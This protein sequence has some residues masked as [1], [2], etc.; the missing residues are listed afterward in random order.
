LVACLVFGAFLR[1]RGLGLQI[2]MDDEWH[3]L[4]FALSRDFW[5]L[6]THFSRAGA[7]SVPFNLYLRA[8]LKS[9]GWTEI[10]IALPSL[11]AGIGLLWVFPRWVWRRFGAVAGAVTAALLAIAP[12]LVFYSRVARAYSAVLLLECLALIAL[13]EWLHTARR[14]HVVGLVVFGAL[15]IWVHASALP[16]LV[17]AVAAAAGHR[18]LRA[19]RAPAP[20]VPLAWHVLLAGLGMLGL[21]G[22]LWFPAL[23][24]PMPEI[25]HASGQVSTHTFLDACQIFIGTAF[26][27]LQIV[28]L[29]VALM[30]LV[31]ASRIARQELLI[32]GAAAGGSLFALL[33]A[34]PNASGVAGVFVRYLLP[35]Y[36]LAGLTV[37]V[38]MA[39]LMAV[40]L[41]Q[42]QILVL[43]ALAILPLGGLQLRN[44]GLDLLPKGGA[45]VLKEEHAGWLE[46]DLE[47]AL[48]RAK[49]EHKLVLVD[50]YADWCAQC[51]ELDEK[52][53]P[54]TSVKQWIAQ[55]AVPIRID[56]DARRKD[57]AT[58][59][60]I[61]SYPTV[62]LLDTE[63]RELRRILGFQK[64]ET[65]RTWLAGK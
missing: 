48:A 34:R 57:L 41:G 53:W 16:A 12:F 29:V 31:I 11:L 65:M 52:T 55:N 19:P 30:G 24:T 8:L 4:D 49:V 14:R 51:K 35:T 46:Q 32:L 39:V 60:Q 59:L 63:G 61:R 44:S 1:L 25:W 28:Y 64:P 38:V 6:F 2:P 40:A 36:L 5:F 27:P 54:E 21:A 58:K 26:A 47:G 10:S 42:A 43:L 22:A 9:F 15:A 37:G 13:C 23:R 3:G 7:N 20:L 17:A 50:I 18:W 45:P 33:G 62:L 56:T